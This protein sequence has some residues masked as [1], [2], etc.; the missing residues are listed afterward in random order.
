M[1]EKFEIEEIAI[2]VTPIG[3]AKLGEPIRKTHDAGIEVE[4]IALKPAVPL[5]GAIAGLKSADY[6]IRLPDDAIAYVQECDLRKR[7]TRDEPMLKQLKQ[8]IDRWAATET[9]FVA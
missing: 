7:K 8:D 3:F 1:P 2:L 4:I 5:A 9:P 6:A